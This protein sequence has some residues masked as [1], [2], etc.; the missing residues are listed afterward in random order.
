[1]HYYDV[2]QYIVYR[3]MTVFKQESKSY[4]VIYNT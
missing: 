4:V 1:M 2:K 3:L